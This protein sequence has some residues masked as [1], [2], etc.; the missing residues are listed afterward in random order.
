VVHGGLPFPVESELRL[1]LYLGLECPEIAM[2]ALLAFHLAGSAEPKSLH[3][4]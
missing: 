4:E 2:R 1:R 3:D